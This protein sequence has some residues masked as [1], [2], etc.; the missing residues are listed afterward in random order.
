MSQDVTGV[1]KN[2]SPVNDKYDRGLP[3]NGRVRV[4]SPGIHLVTE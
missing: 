2:T 1:G 3:L 4:S